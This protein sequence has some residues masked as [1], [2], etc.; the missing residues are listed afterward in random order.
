MNADKGELVRKNPHAGLSPS[1]TSAARGSRYG[2]L[3]RMHA[4]RDALHRRDPILTPLS[5]SARVLWTRITSLLGTVAPQA[6]GKT[7]V[8]LDPLFNWLSTETVPCICSMTCL[9]IERPKPVPPT[10]RDRALSTR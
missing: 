2:V 3:G 5:R 9:T 4:V 7:T 8:N 1:R 6:S 10:S